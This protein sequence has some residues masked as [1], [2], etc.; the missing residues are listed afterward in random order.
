MKYERSG[1]L[2]PES[3]QKPADYDLHETMYAA[4]VISAETYEL[5]GLNSDRK[6]QAEKEFLESGCT[7][8]VDLSVDEEVDENSL[9]QQKDSLKSWKRELLDNQSI[10]S[11]I[12]QAYRWRVNEMIG[13]T[14]MILASKAG[15]MRTFQRWNEFVYGRPDED[16]YR[17]ALDWIANDAEALT[18]SENPAVSEAATAVLESLREKRGYRELLAP[19]QDTFAAVREDHYKDNGYYSLLLDGTDLPTEG[20]VT[21]DIGEPALDHIVHNNLQSNYTIE[22]ATSATW[23][24]SHDRQAVLRPAKYNMPIKRFVG[25]GPGHEIGSH[26]LEKVNGDR[27][28]LALASTGLD[29][30]ESGNEGRA[31]MREQVPYD[32]FDE[33][34]KL[35]RWQDIMRRHVAISY[36]SGVGEDS[37]KSFSETYRFMN[38]IDTM[39]QTAKTPDDSEATRDKAHTRTW[40]LLT[41]VLKGTD[42]KGGAYLKDMVYLEGHVACWLTA[43]MKGS[44]AIANGDL[45]K[46]DINNPRHISLLQ[47]LSLLPEGTE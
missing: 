27:G 7:L 13:N 45:G 21:P 34:G 6:K 25:L 46:F 16:I 4:R 12:R 11:D 30:Y 35:L 24:I 1:L 29:R 5:L 39:Y 41:R 26:L 3:T 37:P 2:L 40:N 17:G 43:S 10:D 36:A 15:D 18:M 8:D 42:G 9:Q 38:A 23:G 44:E 28:P 47:K 20:K 14:N 32:T 22:D 33:F 31:V 19:E